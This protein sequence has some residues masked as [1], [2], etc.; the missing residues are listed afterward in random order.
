[1]GKRNKESSV[2]LYQQLM[3]VIQNQ[4]L[5]GE[6]K[7]NDRI[8]TEIEL[9]REYDV[10]RITVRKAVELLVEEEI[11]IKRQ[12]I[13]TFV[14]QKK[15]CRNIN[16][17]MGFTQSCMAEGN[18]A[19]AQLVSAELA[20]ATVVDA[21]ELKIQE[22]EKIIKIVRVRTCD[23]VPVMLEE[24]H[25]PARFAYLLSHDLTGSLYQI[26]AENGTV[27]EFGLRRAQGP[28]AGIYG[29]RAAMIGGI[30]QANEQEQQYLGVPL[31]KPLLSVKDVSYDREGNPVHNCKSVINPDR[32]KMTVMVNA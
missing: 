13:G 19:G 3:E 6:L 23:G 29:A 5:N 30:C 18:V 22:H 12:G 8:P 31:N 27:M 28:D 14:S 26:L 21:E 10:S 25:F 9:S 17:F 15:L 1:M 32:Y 20:E 4:I 24:N 16:G 11:L 2:P 7:E